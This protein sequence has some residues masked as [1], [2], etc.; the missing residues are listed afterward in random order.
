MGTRVALPSRVPIGKVKIPGEGGR[1]ERTLLVYASEDWIRALRVIVDNVNAIEAGITAA[2]VSFVPSGSIAGTN[3]KLAI[4][5]LD[6]EKAS[7]GSVTAAVA[8]HVAL[9]DPHTQYATDAAMAA[10]DA[11][12]QAFA[13]QRTNHTGTQTAATIS[14]FSAAADARVAAAVGVSVQAFDTDLTAWAGKTAPSGTVVG[15]TDAQ[16]LTNKA[17]TSPDIDGGTVDNAPIGA[18]TPNTGVFTSV[19]S[20]SYVKTAS[21]NFAGLPAAATAGAGAR[22][23]ITDCNSTTFLAAAA[24]GGANKVPVV[25]DGASWLIG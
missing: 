2:E 1:G 23:F 5:E 21:T 19:E 11:A 15:T 9:A 10:A 17:L 14:D 22:H 12:V 13:I 25:S 8:A 16:T 4:E 7:T 18:T 20:T 24:G 6:T 3:V